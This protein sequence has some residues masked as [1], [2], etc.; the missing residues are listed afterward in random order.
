M[1]LIAKVYTPSYYNP[2]SLIR[3]QFVEK[4]SNK[5]IEVVSIDSEFNKSLS[6]LNEFTLDEYSKSIYMQKNITY[7]D[8]DLIYIIKP[9]QKRFWTQS[10]AIEDA[11]NITLEI[12][13]MNNG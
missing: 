6:K 8:D 3:F 5:E 7:Y 12:M 13:G 1:Q 4:N 11:Q 9:N 10:Q 2:L